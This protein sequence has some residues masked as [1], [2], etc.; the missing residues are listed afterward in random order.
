MT[1][2]FGQP[3][4]PMNGEQKPSHPKR[5]KLKVPYQSPE[6]VKHPQQLIT[7]WTV[8][9]WATKD[10]KAKF[11]VRNPALSKER[12]EMRSFLQQQGYVYHAVD[13]GYGIEF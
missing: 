7:R 8:T 3:F 11:P 4:I 2:G 6:Q 10:G 1:M 9:G 12:E 13:L 5:R